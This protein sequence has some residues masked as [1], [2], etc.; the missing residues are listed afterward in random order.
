MS[1]VIGILATSRQ[2]VRAA[3]DGDG[4]DSHRI[5]VRMKFSGSKVPAAIDLHPNSITD[6]ALSAGNG[7]L[8]PFTFR[9][10]RADDPTPQSFGSCGKGSG[11]S[12]RVVA[13]G[14]SFASKTEV[15]CWCS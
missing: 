2:A 3:E 15:F 13:G 8:G 5:Q 11:P 14:G 9:K 1:G 6:E 7:T 12:L 10:L 4:F